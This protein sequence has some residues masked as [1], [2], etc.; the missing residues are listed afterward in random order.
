MK[1]RLILPVILL[2][3]L[4]ALCAEALADKEFSSVAQSY[5]LFVTP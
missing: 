1:K 3:G 2:C 4:I 5:P